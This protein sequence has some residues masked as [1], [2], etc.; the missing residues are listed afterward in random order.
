MI[1]NLKPRVETIQPVKVVPKLAPNTIPSA[2]A[3][4]I[5]PEPTRANSIKVTA[6]LDCKIAVEVAPTK[7]DLK[8]SK[9]Y[10]K[11]LFSK[12]SIKKNQKIKE[13]M[14][15][16]MRPGNGISVEDIDKIVGLKA[17]KNI[18]EKVK[19]KMKDLKLR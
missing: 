11:S 18:N 1:S 3:R 2:L 17:R 13:N 14:L 9:I 10:F 7:I 12:I 19:I 8:Q 16:S 4:L 5:I 15:I 6:E